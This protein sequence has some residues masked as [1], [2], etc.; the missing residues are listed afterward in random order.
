[1]RRVVRIV[2]RRPGSVATL[3]ALMGGTLLGSGGA[4]Q[5]KGAGVTGET[6]IGRQI[7]LRYSEPVQPRSGWNA[8]IASFGAPQAASGRPGSR[9]RGSAIAEL[10]LDARTRVYGRIETEMKTRRDEPGRALQVGAGAGVSWQLSNE[11]TLQVEVGNM[12]G[13]NRGQMSV[14]LQWQL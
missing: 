2:R 5:A 12:P 1:M 8:Q 11:T 7:R 3:L 4:A 10:T 13:Q 14:M 9:I 6:K